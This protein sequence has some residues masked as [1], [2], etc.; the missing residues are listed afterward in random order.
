VPLWKRV[1]AYVIDSLILSFAVLSPLTRPWEEQVQG[2][3]FTEI[4]TA[5]S[6]SFSGDFLF[7]L[8]A[9]SLLVLT[10]WSVMEYAFGQSIGKIFLGLRVESTRKKPLTFLQAV[11]RNVTKLSTVLLVL[12]TLYL[13]FKRT[14]QRYFEVLSD[15]HVVAV[16]RHA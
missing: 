5:F 2:E 10:Y 4:L 1:L 7:L 9:I 6:G 13:L 14:D 8:F 15:T 12:D 11:L 16:V 3:T